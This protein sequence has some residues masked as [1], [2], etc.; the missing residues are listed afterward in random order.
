M[1]NTSP[2]EEWEQEMYFK[3]VYA[4][5]AEHPKLRLINAS[6]N[7]MRVGP[8]T[9]AKLKKQ[10]MR[11]GFP[12]IDIPI[13]SGS[14]SGLKIELKRVKGGTVSPIQK[15]VHALLVDE[16][17]KVVVCRGWVRAVDETIEYLGL[18]MVQPF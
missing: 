17:Y 3:W 5:E 6:M 8:K 12:D 1:K 9:R 14:F 15:E 18:N 13:T 10:G 2:Y 7:G 11:A 4:N 16:G